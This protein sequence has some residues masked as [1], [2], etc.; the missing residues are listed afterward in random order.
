MELQ[1]LSLSLDLIINLFYYNL[2][3]R[4][5]WTRSVA[6]VAFLGCI[7]C[8]KFE[9]ISGFHVYTDKACQKKTCFNFEHLHMLELFPT[10]PFYSAASRC[11][12]HAH[13]TCTWCPLGHNWI[14]YYR[15][16]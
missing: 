11:A 2:D 3:F 12:Q 5:F 1:Y 10:F 6:P 13:F 14:L 16:W 7:H 8:L 15:F 4:L 9:R